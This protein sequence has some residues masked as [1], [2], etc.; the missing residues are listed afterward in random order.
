MAGADRPVTRVARALYSAVLK[1]LGVFWPRLAALLLPALRRA[2]T[3]ASAAA[4]A[5]SHRAVV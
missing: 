1:V 2:H 3:F 5:G 4:F